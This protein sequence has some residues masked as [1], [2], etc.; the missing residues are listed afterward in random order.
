MIGWDIFYFSSATTAQ[1]LTKLD[2]KQVL[3]VLH[4]VCVFWTDRKQ[5]W[6]SWLLIGWDI[7]YFSSANT[8]QN[9]TKLD[10]KQVLCIQQVCVFRT[11]QKNKFGRL[12]PWL[13]ETFSISPLQPT[14]LEFDE[15]LQEASTLRPSPSLWVFFTDPKKAK[16][17]WDFFCFSSATVEKNLMK[18]DRKL[19]LN[20]LYQV[21]VLRAGPS[22]M[23][24]SLTFGLLRH[25]GLPYCILYIHVWYGLS[26]TTSHWTCNWLKES[27]RCPLPRL[28][29][30]VISINK[31]RRSGLWLTD[32]FWT[33]PSSGATERIW[34]NNL[35]GRK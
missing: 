35:T 34:K 5:R 8:A 14:C 13:A 2:R 1:N 23:I 4:E 3:Y 27:T 21:C 26:I 30:S 12:D 28:Y 25:F 29:F 11:D 16:N 31:D 17:G 15:T 20:V 7:F 19:V 9:L 24:A 22:T 18:I 32:T 6:P 33:S 10:W